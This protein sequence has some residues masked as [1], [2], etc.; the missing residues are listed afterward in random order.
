MSP[1]FDTKPHLSVAAWQTESP[2]TDRPLDADRYRQDLELG[3]GGMGVVWA[4]TDLWLNRQVALKRPRDSEHVARVLREA[5]ITARLNHPGIP[6]IFDVG[7][8]AAG[9]FYTMPILAGLPLDQADSS[10]LERVRR[11]RAVAEAMEHA[12]ERGVV[13]RDLKPAN[14]LCGSAGE[15][16]VL[17]WGVAWDAEDPDEARVGTPGFMPPEPASDRAPTTSDVFALGKLIALCGPDPALRAI[18]EKAAHAHPEQRYP[19][20]NAVVLELARWL[21]NQRVDAYTY[22]S[23]ELV[24]LYGWRYR[25]QLSGVSVAGFVLF[26]TVVAAGLALW[27]ERNAAQHALATTLGWQAE[28]HARALDWVGSEYLSAASLALGHS[29]RARGAQLRWSTAAPPQRTR[30]YQPDCGDVQLQPDGRGYCPSTGAVLDIDGVPTG[31]VRATTPV[32]PWTWL[33]DEG[34]LVGTDTE[35]HAT[36]TSATWKAGVR[37]PLLSTRREA[38]VFQVG[39]TV[40]R[41]DRDGSTHRWTSACGT[42]RRVLFASTSTGAVRSCDGRVD[43]FST[44]GTSILP[45]PDGEISTMVWTGG[46][47]AIGTYERELHLWDGQGWRTWDTPEAPAGLEAFRGDHLLVR[48]ENGPGRLLHLPSGRWTYSF[49][50]GAEALESVG[51]RIR[52]RRG[53][54]VVDYWLPD[55]RPP[56]RLDSSAYGGVDSLALSPDG[57]RLATGHA[58]GRTRLWDLQTHEVRDIGQGGSNIVKALEFD[59]LGHLWV[60]NDDPMVLPGLTQI[61]IA[62]QFQRLKGEVVKVNFEGRVHGV[63]DPHQLLFEGPFVDV[64]VHDE[65]FWGLREAS[66]QHGAQ[67]WPALPANHLAVSTAGV[68]LALQDPG[69]AAYGPEGR[70]LWRRPV[71]NPISALQAEGDWLVSGHR[72]GSVRVFDV[73]TAALLAETQLHSRRVA[74]LLVHDGTLFTASWDGQVYRID[75]DIL[76]R[77]APSAEE[78]DARWAVSPQRRQARQ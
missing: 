24:R 12:H 75:L 39:D 35:I 55:A 22:G 46:G 47:L 42:S 33:M 16:W 49:P 26:T 52:W 61:P 73:E 40:V 23:S 67:S 25:W 7:R 53:D 13:H 30:R 6:P 21:E 76:S 3:R 36:A 1:D 54:Q 29:P 51:D 69:I 18:A 4:V 72:D 58:N 34:L 9:P 65:E 10:L 2:G 71:P 38:T 20:A 60:A 41:I 50:P 28:E 14:I 56:I 37:H 8:D 19:S 11:I 44:T 78:V 31:E 15:V 57:T 48:M 64:D 59:G 17:D 77:P 32:G 63:V 43:L 70:L 62:R 74:D 5:A 66:V 68:F 45:T 27:N